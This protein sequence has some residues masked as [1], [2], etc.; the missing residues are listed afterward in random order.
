MQAAC[1]S[2][3][4]KHLRV[5]LRPHSLAFVSFSAPNLCRGGFFVI[6]AEVTACGV[7]AGY[8][9]AAGYRDRDTGVMTV[10]DSN[11]YM[12]LFWLSGSV[13]NNVWLYA[14]GVRLVYAH[15]RAYGFSVRCLQAFALA[16]FGRT[17]HGER[18]T[19]SIH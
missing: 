12:T 17:E 19:L 13:S 3:V 2:V 9:P 11:G 1:L 14:G 8:Y 16:I 15:N 5:A 7:P 6:F 10:Y 4:S 18:N